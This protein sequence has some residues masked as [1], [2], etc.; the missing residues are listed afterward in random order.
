[1]I[2][3]VSNDLRQCLGVDAVSGGIQDDH[4]RLL[5][6]FVQNLQYISGDEFAVIQSVGSGIFLC[7]LYGFLHDFH[8]DNLSGRRCHELCDGTGAAVEVEHS[9]VTA[10]Q[11]AHIISCRLVQYLRT[12]GVSLE[13]GECGDL[14]FQ[15]QQ[16]LIKK[17]LSVQQLRTITL[18]HI[19]DGIIG[20]M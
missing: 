11:V 18:H 3:A 1:M 15:P 7:C 6:H 20:D 5:F 10:A 19:C 17:L 13:K 14:E 4:I 12:V 8:A 9:L 2:H 16:F